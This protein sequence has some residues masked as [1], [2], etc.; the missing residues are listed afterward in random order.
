MD[1]VRDRSTH[2]LPL[3]LLFW[4]LQDLSPGLL[5][6]ELRRSFLS[7]HKT[8]V[9]G[10]ALLTLA[11]PL[12]QDFPLSPTCLIS[13]PN[14]SAQPSAGSAWSAGLAIP[15]T[16]CIYPTTVPHHVDPRLEA[17]VRPHWCVCVGLLFLHP[18][19]FSVT[20]CLRQI[21]ALTDKETVQAPNIC[22]QRLA[23][24]RKTKLLK[25]RRRFDLPR[26]TKR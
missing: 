19:P 18:I 7:R 5:D 22:P 16:V 1:F 11:G 17:C 2:R 12:Q 4:L 13:E 20:P 9:I 26:S 21:E 6:A 25:D 8:V 15:A 10:Q 24:P 23:L 3:Q 14:S